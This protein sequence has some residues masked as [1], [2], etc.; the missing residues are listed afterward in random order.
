MIFSLKKSKSNG[1][2]FTSKQMLKNL[3]SL[4]YI[5][6]I[7]E[8]NRYYE[9]V[10]VDFKTYFNVLASSYGF[11]ADFRAS[12]DEVILSRRSY[13]SGLIKYDETNLSNLCLRLE[14]LYYKFDVCEYVEKI[15]KKKRATLN[16]GDYSITEIT[17]EASW[18]HSKLME[19]TN[20]LKEATDKK[21]YNVITVEASWTFDVDVEDFDP[22]YV[23]VTGAAIEDA[24]IELND[25]IEN[26]KLSVDDFE[27]NVTEKFKE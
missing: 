8:W 18:I 26:G 20:E 9:T 6:T 12:S 10:T 2:L 19:L 11:T 3:A 24:V 22:E 15:V 16:Q 5:K 21:R 17:D 1:E 27:F 14:E 4:G 7:Y 23:N 25:L 13:S